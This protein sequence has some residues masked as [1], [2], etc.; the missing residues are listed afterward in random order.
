[1]PTSFSLNSN[2]NSRQL[3]FSEDTDVLAADST[4]ECTAYSPR[5]LAKN[6]RVFPSL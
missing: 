3:I 4:C 6:S 1:M 5:T 2:E